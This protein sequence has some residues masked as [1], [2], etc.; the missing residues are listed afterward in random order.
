MRAADQRPQQLAARDVADAE[1]RREHR[2]EGVRVLELEEEVERG[3]EHRAVHRRR[4]QQPGRD[5][6][7]V[8]DQ[9]AAGPGTSPTSAADAD[10]DRQQEQQRLDAAR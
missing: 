5:E 7:V 3:V 8:R 2:V 9:L 10:A 6:L 4:R 1:R